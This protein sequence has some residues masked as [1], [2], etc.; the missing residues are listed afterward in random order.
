MYREVLNTIIDKS[1]LYDYFIKRFD[2]LIER[3]DFNFN[4]TDLLF[5]NYRLQSL[6]NEFCIANV[7]CHLLFYNR[8]PNSNEGQCGLCSRLYVKNTD[9]FVSSIK[10]HFSLYFQ[11]MQFSV[12]KLSY[13]LSIEKNEI[14]FRCFVFV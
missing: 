11:I 7:L 12:M 1:E 4:F 13:Y 3:L 14:Y 8:S 5:L 10:Y 2:E 6:K 9:D